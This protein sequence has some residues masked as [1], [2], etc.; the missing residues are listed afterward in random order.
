MRVARVR[1]HR[2]DRRMLGLQAVLGKVLED[3]GLHLDFID[4]GAA[5]DGVRNES[6]GSPVR[7]I[8]V[9]GRVE[10]RALLLGVPG[11]LEDLDQVAGG[12]D[13]H[14]EPLDQLDGSGVDARDVRDGIVRRVLERHALESRPAVGRAP[15]QI[16]AT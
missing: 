9:D 14:A 15:L 7:R 2:D 11:G 5:T 4:D 10:V 12:N 16:P 1:A 3:L 8:G 13:L 6:P